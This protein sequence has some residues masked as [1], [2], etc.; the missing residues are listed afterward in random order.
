MQ[1]RM[2]CEVACEAS[3][4]HKNIP[5]QNLRFFH[6][7]RQPGGASATPQMQTR[8]RSRGD[9]PD[10]KDKGQGEVKFEGNDQG[11]TSPTLEEGRRI[12]RRSSLSNGTKDEYTNGV[13][14][15]RDS[16]EDDTGH[17][18]TESNVEHE[19]TKDESQEEEEDDDEG[20]YHEDL[21]DAH[22]THQNNQNRVNACTS[23][24]TITICVCQRI[25]ARSTVS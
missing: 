9:T 11:S 19:L 5:A 14:V 23:A 17:E 2:N 24:F 12:T 6:F 15:I 3:N 4:F 8:T 16:D 13:Q 20:G 1:R 10:R 21:E 22:S 7:T 25:C 18:A